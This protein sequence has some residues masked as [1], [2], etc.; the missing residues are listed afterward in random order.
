[1]ASESWWSKCRLNFQKNF[2]IIF[3]RTGNWNAF[4]YMVWII[5]A[6]CKLRLYQM[7]ASGDINKGLVKIFQRTISWQV[8]F[9]LIEQFCRDRLKCEKVIDYRQRTASDTEGSTGL[10]PKD[11]TNILFCWVE[12]LDLPVRSYKYLHFLTSMLHKINIY[13]YW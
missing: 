3:F 13:I 12:I 6:I 7:K 4:N 2:K 10:W 11:S 5:I 9:H 8:C 1:M